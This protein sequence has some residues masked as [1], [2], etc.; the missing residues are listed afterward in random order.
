MG[1]VNQGNPARMVW[2][3]LSVAGCI[4][5][6]NATGDQLIQTWNTSHMRILPNTALEQSCSARGYSH[7]EGSSANTSSW[8]NHMTSRERSQ[9]EMNSLLSQLP[10]PWN[11]ESQNA[12]ICSTHDHSQFPGLVHFCPH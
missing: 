7:H 2:S 11:T 1:N 9:N 6:S 10:G 12:V 5:G 4:Q 8:L 3:G